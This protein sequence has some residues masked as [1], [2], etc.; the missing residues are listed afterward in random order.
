[1]ARGAAV[2]ADTL[3]GGAVTLYGG[4]KII[5]LDVTPMSLSIETVGGVA[6]RLVERNTTLPV[7]Y[8]RI[9]TTAAPFQRSVDIHVLQGERPMARDNKTIGRFRLGGIKPAPPGF[10][11]LRLP[12][13]LMQTVF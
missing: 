6:T 2:Q 11:K 7:H 8:S 13:I 9:F 4:N 5:L 12:L 10:R 3:S 1:M